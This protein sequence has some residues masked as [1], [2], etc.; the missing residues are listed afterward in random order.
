LSD[1]EWKEKITNSSQYNRDEF[2]IIAKVENNIVGI[3]GAEKKNNETW[4]LKS[5]YVQSEYR[6]QGI[7]TKLLQSIIQILEERKHAEVIELTVNTI[8]KAAVH[9][10]TKCEFQIKEVLENQQSGDGNL[11]IKFIMYRNVCTIHPKYSTI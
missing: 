8:Q 5:V 4:I 10:Y 9:V 2:F 1:R 11:Y 3:V 6:G 7:G